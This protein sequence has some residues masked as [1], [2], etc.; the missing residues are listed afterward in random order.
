MVLSESTNKT[1]LIEDVDFILGTT[2]TEYTANDKKRNINRWYHFTIME[3]LKVND[4]W[5]IRDTSATVDTVA[6]TRSY[7][8][9]AAA[10]LN[11]SDI[12]EIKRVEI[13]Y[14]GTAW[15][16]AEPL[17]QA[18]FGEALNASQSTVDGN[19][20]E[21]EPYYDLRD[22]YID[23]Y[24]APESAVS[25]GLKIWYT[26]T[27]TELSANGD[28]PVIAEEFHRI[29][30]LGAAYDWAMSRNLAMA[31]NLRGE[32]EVMLQKLRDF[33]SQRITDRVLTAKPAYNSYE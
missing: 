21:S 6:D 33:Y 4:E 5:D 32:I 20:A 28:E 27:A 10:G 9:S 12:L 3:I 11:M 13:S 7:Q 29:L 8:L 16:K 31:A 24:P 2:S 23:M 1:G 17:E 22:D 14:D 30:S 26:K 19:F 25:S 15:Y 18:E